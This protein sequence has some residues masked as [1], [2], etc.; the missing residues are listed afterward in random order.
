MIPVDAQ[1]MMAKRADATTVDQSG[2][3]ALY[4]SQPQAVAKVIEDTANS[5]D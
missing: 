2:S 4:V 5:V 1:R 3:N